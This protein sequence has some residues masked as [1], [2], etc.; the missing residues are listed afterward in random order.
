MTAQRSSMFFLLGVLLSTF[1]GGGVRVLLSPEVVSRWVEDVVKKK[2]PKFNFK[3]ETAKL[4]LAD[5]WRPHLAVELTGLNVSA[6]DKCTTE[7]TLKIDRVIVPV[8]F[9][10]LLD[11]KVQ[12]GHV[13]GD[14]VELTVKPNLC[15]PHSSD[16]T[17]ELESLESFFRRR[18][19]KEVVN[20]TK[21]IT[22]LS[23]EN[24]RVRDGVSQEPKFHISN[25]QIE[26]LARENVAK[27]TFEFWPGVDWVGTQP[28]GPT[29]TALHIGSDGLQWSAKSNLKE[30]QIHLKGG[31]K[32]EKSHVVFDAKWTDVPVAPLA[33]LLTRWQ[34]INLHQIDPTNQWSSCHLNAQGSIR[35]WKDLAFVANQCTSTGDIGNIQIVNNEWPLFRG[36]LIPFQ[37][38]L[39]RV[40][41]RKVAELFDIK[42]FKNVSNFGELTGQF[43]F[44][45]GLEWSISGTINGAELYVSLFDGS[46]KRPLGPLAFQADHKQRRVKMRVTGDDAFAMRLNLDV[47]YEQDI[48]AP[49]IV[50]GRLYS[51]DKVLIETGSLYGFP[52]QGIDLKMTAD[53]D[54]HEFAKVRGTAALADIEL[55]PQHPFHPILQQLGLALSPDEPVRLHKAIGTF[56]VEA[57]RIHVRGPIQTSIVGKELRFDTRVMTGIFQEG[58]IE[59]L[60]NARMVQRFDLEGS[61]QHPVTQ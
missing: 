10:R 23:I 48:G 61:L 6:K 11:K 16:W 14:L 21:F 31:W 33:L 36:K 13:R 53:F 26:F 45:E 38:E 27:A 28:F 5:G 41:L 4:S 47:D 8:Q 7:S 25:L 24:L 15:T 35:N 18:W 3:F 46:F 34:M 20:T 52:F 9:R 42:A 60:D 54:G 1:V 49:A 58:E 19:N 59:L 22:N 56:D 37:A 30:G 44:D 40:N 29:Q 12:L 43:V 39:K 17:S 55:R 2:Q 32:V 50:R 57:E 51:K